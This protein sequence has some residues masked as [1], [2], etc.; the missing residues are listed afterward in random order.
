MGTARKLYFENV[1]VGEELPPLV[2]PTVDRVSIARYTG[3]IEDFNR[4]YVDE[5]FAKRSGFP[6]VC[7]PGSMA[8]GFLA[9]LVADWFK[10]GQVKRLSA[11]FVKIIW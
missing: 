2:K 9:Q 10:P 8:M 6:T 3:A 5:D 11:R 1:R 7:V 4:L